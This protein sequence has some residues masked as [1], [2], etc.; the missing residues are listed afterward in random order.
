MASQQ[1]QINSSSLINNVKRISSYVNCEFPNICDVIEKLPIFSTRFQI[2]KKIKSCSKRAIYYVMDTKENIKDY[3]IAKFI[4]KHNI[5]PKT[6]ALLQYMKNCKNKYIYK[7]Y[8]VGDAGNFYI[9]LSKYID[10]DTLDKALINLSHVDRIRIIQN[11]LEGID[12]LHS[13]HIQHVDIKPSNIIVTPEGIPIIIDLDSAKII[14]NEF[15]Y[16]NI[17]TGTIP[18]IP[19]EIY[20]N[21]KYYIKSDIW[22]IGVTLLKIFHNEFL[23]NK[24]KNIKKTLSTQSISS[25]HNK[26]LDIKFYEEFSQFNFKLLEGRIGNELCAIIKIMLTIDST[27]RPSAREL[28]Q[29]LEKVP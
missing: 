21:R 6:I 27:L 24:L 7:I 2:I 19:Y 14:K 4:V 29:Q 9:I 28:L 10:G 20:E 16:D 3:A 22:S 8:E 12:F 1:N 18:Y 13:N 15:E 26:K 23:D 5:T 17:I 11:I 25:L